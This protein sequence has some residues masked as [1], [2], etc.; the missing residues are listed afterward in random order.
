MMETLSIDINAK[1]L[2]KILKKTQDSARIQT[3]DLLITS[4]TLLP[5]WSHTIESVSIIQYVY[6]GLWM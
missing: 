2:F 6:L 3:Q 4:Q 1:S 5:L